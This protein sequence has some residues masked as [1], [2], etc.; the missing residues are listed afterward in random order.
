MGHELLEMKGMDKNNLHLLMMKFNWEKVNDF[1]MVPVALSSRVVLVILLTPTPGVF[2]VFV[3]FFQGVL[4]H[5]PPSL[6]I[7]YDGYCLCGELNVNCS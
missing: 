6:K 5:V 1:L 3:F 2:L 7:S 4:T